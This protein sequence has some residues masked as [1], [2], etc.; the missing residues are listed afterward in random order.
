MARI[1]LCAMCYDELL[2]LLSRDKTIVVRQGHTLMADVLKRTCLMHIDMTAG[3]AD[4]TLMSTED[5]S[6]HCHVCLGATNHEVNVS[7]RTLTSLTDQATRIV[8]V[9]VETIANR[10]LVVGLKK[11]LQDQWMHAIVIITLELNH[12][13]DVLIRFYR[14]NLHIF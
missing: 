12:F 4:H 8:T 11:A 7:I 9:W 14:A 13:F 3:S 2:D 6:Y 10:L 5:R 1:L